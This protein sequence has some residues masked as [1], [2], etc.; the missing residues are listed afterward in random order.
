MTVI[1]IQSLKNHE[2]EKCP[3][4]EVF[5]KQRYIKYDAFLFDKKLL[6]I[7]FFYSV[8][9]TELM[10]LIFVVIIFEWREDTSIKCQVK[11]F[12]L[13]SSRMGT[14]ILQFVQVSMTNIIY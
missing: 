3:R 4:Q 13:C 12:T 5:M 2:S 10:V 6:D 14:I 8:F 7:G 1:I 9:S 11:I